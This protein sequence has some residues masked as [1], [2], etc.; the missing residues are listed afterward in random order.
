MRLNGGLLLTGNRGGIHICIPALRCHKDMLISLRQHSCSIKMGGIGKA[1]GSVFERCLG[2]L[3]QMS[4]LRGEM[5][6]AFL[7]AADISDW[8]I[9]IVLIQTLHIC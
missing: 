1:V 7:G 9:R 4:N 2:I 5:I 8:N 6:V 3:M